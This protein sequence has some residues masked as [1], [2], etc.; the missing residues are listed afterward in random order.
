MSKH[1]TYMNK[2]NVQVYILYL[3]TKNYNVLQFLYSKTP[4]YVKK[5]TY[6][7]VHLLIL[8][9]TYFILM[10]IEVLS[11]F[12]S[13]ICVTNLLNLIIHFVLEGNYKIPYKNNF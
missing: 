4:C 7:K 11:Y 13:H 1:E 9:I 8:Q 5:K 3:T 2:I 6:M 12:Q 10:L